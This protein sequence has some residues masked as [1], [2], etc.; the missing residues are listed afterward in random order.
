M[1]EGEPPSG[2]AVAGMVRACRPMWGVRD[3]DPVDEGTDFVARVAC[4]TPE[5]D[6]TAV[7]KTTTAGFV[8]PDIARAESRLY[9]LVGRETDVPVPAV[10]GFVDDHGTYPA[11][12]YLLEHVDGE[13]VQ[14]R[15]EMLDPEARTPVVR[16]A[17]TNLAT[18][19]G[20]GTLPRV[21]K[22][23]VRDGD[24]A[25]LDGEYGPVDDFREWFRAGVAETCDALAG[26]TFFPD[27][28]A[29]PERFADLAEPLRAELFARAD[30]LSDPDP[31]GTATGT[32]GTAICSWTPT[33]ARRGPSLTGPTLRPPSRRTISRRSNHTCLTQSPNR[34]EPK[35]SGR[36][37]A[38][39]TPMRA[40]S[41]RSRPLSRIEWKRTCWPLAPR[42]WRVS[43]CGSKMRRPARKQ[44]ANASTARS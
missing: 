5:G 34:P 16:K 30:T 24:L 40:T 7:L 39:L 17:G 12:F 23:G 13:S 41:G 42:R 18:L 14:G 38:M 35:R 43:R 4:A 20:L 44:N 1:S 29:E 6:R 28:A 8:T 21:G 2:D 36:C 25:V 15:P 11:P 9:E 32:T 31:P 10:Y 37:S 33:P 19:H 22:V 27:R 3:H 26:G